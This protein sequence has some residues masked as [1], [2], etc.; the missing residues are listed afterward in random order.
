MSMVSPIIAANDGKPRRGQVQDEVISKIR[1]GLMVGA[2]VPGQVMSLRKL[3][4]HLGTSSMPVREALSQLV[5]ANVL[6]ALPNRSVRVP[7]LSESRLRELTDV[8]VAIE[9]MATRAAATNAT[10]ELIDELAGIN[11]KLIAAIAKRSI[12]HCLS[13]NQEFHFRLYDAARSEVLMP[14]IEALWLQS[15]P[16][17]Y[18]SL[19]SP[20]MPWDASAHAEVLA[21]LRAGD[22]R[23]AERAMARDIRTTAKN[24]LS[25]PSITR[26]NG[27]LASP[28]DGLTLFLAPARIGEEDRA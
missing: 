21:A 3:A 13:I 27:P 8:R 14:L 2:F 26:S 16:T 4:A 25:G 5:A 10:P 28:L 9:G 19:L 6:E 11:R 12:V 15:G 24:L 1:Q 17:M 23:K 7:R 22:S 18:F 20:D